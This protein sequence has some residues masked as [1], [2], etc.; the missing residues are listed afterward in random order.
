MKCLA[1]VTSARQL[2]AHA[3][4]HVDAIVGTNAHGH[5]RYQRSADLQRDACQAH[6]AEVHQHC[7][8]HRQQDKQTRR[9]G[10]EHQAGDQQHGSHDLQDVENFLV[11]NGLCERYR[12]CGTAAYLNLHLG[13]EAGSGVLA[14]TADQVLR[15]RGTVCLHEHRDETVAIVGVDIAVEVTR[16]A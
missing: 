9:Q 11:H 3:V 7:R 2:L 14:H 16:V 6:D 15:V 8:H 13:S 10:A 1:C 4:D 5:G 12:T